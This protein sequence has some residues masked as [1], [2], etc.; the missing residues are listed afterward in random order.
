M[1][2]VHTRTPFG[3]LLE[4]RREA[5]FLT[6]RQAADRL[7]IGES[8]YR[9]WLI[10][11]GPRRTQLPAV[12]EALAIRL[13]DL[14]LAWAQTRTPGRDGGAPAK[15]AQEALEALAAETPGSDQRQAE[16]ARR[17]GQASDRTPNRRRAERR[18]SA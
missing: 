17:S 14:A 2:Q 15:E 8:T 16:G 12:A 4:Q 10:G 3:R 5:L 18:K 13:E 9:L 1:T 11:P 6:Q 7:R